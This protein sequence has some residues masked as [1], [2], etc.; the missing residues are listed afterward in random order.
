MREGFA[1]IAAIFGTIFS[2]A[3]GVWQEPLT[4][5]LVCMAVDYISG[6]AASVRDKSG[7]SSLVGS[8]GLARTR[9]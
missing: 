6:I 2:F 3:F 8:W 9:D 4:L 7:L 1:S 5:L